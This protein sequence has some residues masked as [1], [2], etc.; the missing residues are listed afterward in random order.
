MPSRRRRRAL[1]EPAGSRRV[2]RRAVDCSDIGAVDGSGPGKVALARRIRASLGYSAP[3]A[4]RFR[5]IQNEI[6]LAGLLSARYPSRMTELQSAPLVGVHMLGLIAVGVL[7]IPC[8]A[9]TTAG[10][11]KTARTRRSDDGWGNRPNEAPSRALARW[12]DPAA[13][14]RCSPTCACAS[15]AG[16]TTSAG[17]RAPPGAGAAAHPPPRP[18]RTT[19]AAAPRRPDPRGAPARCP[20]SDLNVPLLAGKPSKVA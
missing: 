19:S 16:S 5:P 12:R 3:H 11:T 4:E 17:P 2:A 18:H 20:R 9:P 7:M 10:S 15:P 6:S 14:R 13:R 8:A 1:R